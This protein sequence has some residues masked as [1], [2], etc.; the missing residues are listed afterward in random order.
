MFSRNNSFQ[1]LPGCQLTF[2]SLRVFTAG[3]V[4]V[5][6]EEAAVAVA[7][8]H[9]VTLPETTTGAMTVVM[10]ETTIVM[11]TASTDH[12]GDPSCFLTSCLN[13]Y[14]ILLMKCEIF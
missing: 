2:F 6:G 10:T 7:A 13:D 1:Y 8:A 9:H 5:V 12:T 11:M 3:V 14:F 4:E